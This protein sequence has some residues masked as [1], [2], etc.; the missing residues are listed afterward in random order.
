E[1][2][3]DAFLFGEGQSRVVVSVSPENVQAFEK[4]AIGISIFKLGTVTEGTIN[5]DNEDW[6]LMQSWYQKYDTAI[7]KYLSKEEAGSALS[8]L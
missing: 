3:K 1:I 5:I 4:N 7:E 8:A 2:R 6:G